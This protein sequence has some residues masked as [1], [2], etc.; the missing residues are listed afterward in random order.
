LRR[1]L[2]AGIDTQTERITGEVRALLREA[3]P[4]APEGGARP[5]PRAATAPWVWWVACAALALA[6]VSAALWWRT[7]KLLDGLTVQLTQLAQRDAAALAALAPAG[8]ALATPGATTPAS[9]SPAATTPTAAPPTA[10]SRC[11]WPRATPRTC[12]CRIRR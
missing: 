12:S 6:L 8:A 9:A 7:V 4:R 1:A 2:V 5:P 10:R 3:L 11:R